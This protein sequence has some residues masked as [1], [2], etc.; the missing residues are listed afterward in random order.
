MCSGLPTAPRRRSPLLSSRQYPEVARATPLAKR[1][2]MMS[3]KIAVLGAGAIGS[4][5]GADLHKSG[6]DVVLI[7]QWPAHVEAMKANGLRVDDVR[8]RAAHARARVSP[9]RP[10]RAERA[11]RYRAARREILRHALDGRA[12]QALSEAGRIRG[13]PAE[14]HERRRDRIDRRARAHGR[15]RR[16]ALCRSVHAG[17]RPAQHDACDDV[18][19]LRRARR[20]RDAAR[21]RARRR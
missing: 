20:R 21:A 8:R 18:V 9:V 7:D 17:R 19:R 5:V 12:H 10:R 11:V 1:I 13:R 14:R 4:S 6:Y 16:R 3:K 15:V 2:Q